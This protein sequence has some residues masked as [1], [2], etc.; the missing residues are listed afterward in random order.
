MKECFLITSY[1]DNDEKLDVLRDTLK[2]L[3]KYIYK[4]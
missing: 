2:S 3:N 4:L 1:C